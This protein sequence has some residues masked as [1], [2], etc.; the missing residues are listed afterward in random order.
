MQLD[1]VLVIA[2]LCHTHKCLFSCCTSRKP[3]A[4]LQHKQSTDLN[5][6]AHGLM[7]IGT[8]VPMQLMLQEMTLKTSSSACGG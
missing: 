6:W 3:E 1:Y 2:T 8:S 7:F 5:T 4:E